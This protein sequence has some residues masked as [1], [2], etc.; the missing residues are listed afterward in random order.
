MIFQTP[1]KPRLAVVGA[2][3]MVGRALL[4]H[5][6]LLALDHLDLHLVG[7]QRSA[8]QTMLV[9]GRSYTIEALDDFDFACVDC[10]F[11]VAGFR[12]FPVSDYA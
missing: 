7:S 5:L 2:S 10:T 4:A 11:F 3:G 9:D 12:Y 1:D 6:H 8:G